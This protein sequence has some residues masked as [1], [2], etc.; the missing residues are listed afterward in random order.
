[1]TS[2]NPDYPQTPG[3]H[4]LPDG[5]VV[6]HLPASAVSASRQGQVEALFDHP[7]WLHHHRQM[8][9]AIIIGKVRTIFETHS[10]LFA[11]KARFR[12]DPHKD[13]TGVYVDEAFSIPNP[14][15]PFPENLNY[16]LTN[17]FRAMV[18]GCPDMDDFLVHLFSQEIT[19]EDMES[20]LETGWDKTFGTGEFSRLAAREMAEDLNANLEKSGTPK[21]ASRI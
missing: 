21:P 3:V 14:D 13:E 9:A 6:L 15:L 5:S 17:A 16:S 8:K 19:R 1:M 10:R 7:L 12:Y 2:P 11:F 20:C 18:D 4:L